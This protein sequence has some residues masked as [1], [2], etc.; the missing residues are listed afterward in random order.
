MPEVRCSLCG[1]QT[2]VWEEPVPACPECDR[3]LKRAIE[4]RLMGSGLEWTD[5]GP[6]MES[7]EDARKRARTFRMLG[8]LDDE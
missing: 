6:R 4:R 5:D 8:V 1:Y 3:S 2:V 7:P